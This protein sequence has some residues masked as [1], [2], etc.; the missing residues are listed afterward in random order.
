MSPLPS[1][2]GLA[3]VVKVNTIFDAPKVTDAVDRAAIRVLGAQ[4]AFIRTAAR[5][6][7]RKRKKSSAPGQPPSSHEGT[8][9]RFLI[10]AV[11]PHAKSVIIGPAKTNQVFFGKDGQPVTGTVPEVLEKGGSIRILEVLRFG[12]W[13]RIDLRMA[14]DYYAGLPKRLHTAKIAARPY[15]GPA[16]EKGL[17]DLDR[18]WRNSV[19]R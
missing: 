19:T 3:I 6:S 8:L 2:S 14:Q 16:L 11:D 7:I 1:Q 10:F 4:G 12:E 9:K 15:M 17:A 18:K 5:S 13:R